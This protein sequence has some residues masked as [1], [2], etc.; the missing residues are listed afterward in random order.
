M[1]DNHDELR[2]KQL[3]LYDLLGLKEC[4]TDLEQLFLGLTEQVK[5][6]S[7]DIQRK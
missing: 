2:E 4:A 3:E 7:A 5:G 6:L 1:E